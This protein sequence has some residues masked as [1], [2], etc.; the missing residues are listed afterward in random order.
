MSQ[1]TLSAINVAHV[2]HGEITFD[3]MFFK[4]FKFNSDLISDEGLDQDEDG[5][6]IYSFSVRSKILS[7]LFR[8]T[9]DDIESYK[10]SFNATERCPVNEKYRIQIE[11]KTKSMIRK[12]YSPFYQPSKYE[13]LGVAKK[14]KEAL[15]DTTNIQGSLKE[16]GDEI[17]YLMINNSILKGFLENVSS[18]TEDFK[19]EVSHKNFSITAFTKG[20]FVKEKEI[21]KQP[22]AVNIVFNTDELL[23]L[24][25]YDSIDKKIVY[26]LKDFKTFL[27]LGNS[28]NFVEVW[29]KKPG[30]PA[31]FELSK[32]SCTIQFVQVTDGENNHHLEA[33]HTRVI[34]KEKITKKSV[35]E[36][37]KKTYD[38]T[39]ELE[40]EFNE[41]LFVQDDD[42]N[43]VTDTTTADQPQVPFKS[44]TKVPKAPMV[45]SMLA[46]MEDN[47]EVNGL[48]N[49][50]AD[51]ISWGD[52]SIKD[53]KISQLI[54]NSKNDEKRLINE[55]KMKYL[56]DLKRRKIANKENDE[57]ELS[58]ELGPTQDITKVKGIFD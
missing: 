10:I 1:I 36:K 27:N 9:E 50:K 8:K 31:L 15:L 40:Q 53:A 35:R 16:D 6:V 5:D 30:D 25:L 22:M 4:S 43:D 3:A 47:V 55:A 46:P 20:I 7:I 58:N 21:L 39:K 23:D 32:N 33:R 44:P 29:F 12:Q 2:S 51:E 26:R 57:D 11:I 49:S 37:K 42:N 34:P 28:G 14:Y 52:P 48:Q 13:R 38:H 17:N 54:N 45:T 56:N 41:P 19:L 18:Q 24:K